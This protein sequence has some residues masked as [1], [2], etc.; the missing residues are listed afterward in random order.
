MFKKPKKRE[1]VNTFDDELEWGKLRDLIHK[2][3]GQLPE[4][5]EDVDDELDGDETIDYGK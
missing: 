5:H 4:P 1:T 2:A 3:F